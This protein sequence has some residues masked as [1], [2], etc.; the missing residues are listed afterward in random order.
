MKICVLQPDDSVST[1]APG[2]DEPPRDLTALLPDDQL[3]HVLLRKVTVH[4]QLRTLRREGFDIFVNLCA[5]CLDWDLPSVDVIDALTRL[6]LPHTGTVA[7]LYDPGPALMKL[8]ATY[9][10]VATPDFAV[11]TGPAPDPGALADAVAGLGFPLVVTPG[12]AGGPPA[13]DPASPCRTLAEV[14]AGVGRL[15]PECDDIVIERHIPGRAFS[16]LVLAEPGRPGQ[17]RALVP[18]ELEG[19]NLP[20]RAEP[21]AGRL[22]AAAEAIFEVCGGVGYC[23]MDFRVADDGTPWFSG[24]DFACSVLHPAGSYSAADYC[25]AHEGLGP[26]GFLRHIIAE[27]LARHRR[28]AKPYVVARSAASGYGLRASRGI[29]AGEVVFRGEERPQRLVTRRHVERNWSA[30]QQE[31]FRRYAYPLADELFVLWDEAPEG[32][33]PQ[34]HSCAPNTAFAGLDVIALRAIAAGEELTLDYRCFSNERM[35]PFDCSCGAPA[36]RG[37]ITGQPGNTLDRREQ[38]RAQADKDGGRVG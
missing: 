23:R 5:G 20:C 3:V 28:A 10:G 30:E 25:L 36:C 6:G 14:V 29:A 19:R 18:N 37:R 11:V 34:N 22:R 12:H 16:V 27:G 32:W 17:G 1:R 26:D 31:V 13:V 33:A 35:E 4:A 9:A 38:R 2:R 8:C 24:A 15:A 21:L 7:R